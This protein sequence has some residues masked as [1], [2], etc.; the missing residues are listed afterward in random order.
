LR[1][2]PDAEQEFALDP[3]A[4]AFVRNVPVEALKRMSMNPQGRALALDQ[5]QPVFERARTGVVSRPKLETLVSAVSG[6]LKEEFTALESLLEKAQFNIEHGDVESVSRRFAHCDDVGD[7]AFSKLK[8]FVQP[9][10]PVT[11]DVASADAAAWKKWF[12]S[13]YLPYRW[14][15]T[16]RGKADAEVEET[17]GKFSE[18]YCRHF[19]HVHSDPAL[20]A[21]QI[22]A[23]WRS[24][25]LQDAVSLI[26]LV[27]NLPWFFWDSFE[28]ALAA[29]GLHKHESHD[30]FAP[31][32]SH[33]TVCKPALISGRWDATGSDYRKMLEERSAEEWGGK[34]VHYLAG[35]DQLNAM[36]PV[37]S[38]AVLVL[39]YLASDDTLHS[40]LA[41]A[42]TTH[43]DQ[44]GV[45]YQNLGKGVGAL[46]GE[47]AKEIEPLASMSTPT[48]E[49]VTY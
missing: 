26:L 20:S 1:G 13:E 8:L 28:R 30:C 9:P 12:H 43:A 31:L 36:K 49:R 16:Q 10:K 35:V 2:Y 42:G 47:P 15:Q 18:W 33:T 23:Q 5:I 38:P 6:E 40:D 37:P 21:V 34:P 44:L 32:P 27:D 4:A 45:H 25:I 46:L 7:A 41:A 17:V 39:N 11:L 22:L 3:A 24:L 29:A 19:T 14:W 48:M